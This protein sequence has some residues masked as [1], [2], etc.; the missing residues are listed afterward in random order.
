MVST[1]TQSYTGNTVTTIFLF[2]SE[3]F[4][5]AEQPANV[6]NTNIATIKHDNTFFTNDHSVSG[7][8]NSFEIQEI[9]AKL[10]ETN[11]KVKDLEDKIKKEIEKVH[12]FTKEI[13]KVNIKLNHRKEIEENLQKNIN[14]EKEELEQNKKTYEVSEEESDTLKDKIGKE[15]TDNELLKNRNKL[16]HEENS[17]I[18]SKFDFIKERLLKVNFKHR[19]IKKLY[20]ELIY[21]AKKHG[22]YASIFHWRCDPYH[23]TLSIIKTQAG[24]IFGGFTTQTWEGKNFDKEDENAFCFSLDK[25]KIYNI[26][27]GKKAIYASP[28]NG[29]SFQNCIFQVEDKF[30]ENGGSCDADIKHYDNVDEELEINGGNVHFLIED[31]EVF[32]VYFEF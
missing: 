3:S 13:I 11:Q 6:P 22:G 1:L 8:F 32:A 12:N 27:K 2:P 29:P 15:K 30:F 26:V 25:H 19:P 9:K 7:H 17:A 20:F 24:L 14:K 21:R 5:F 23:N 18:T 31:L 10:E 16:L 28:D 4:F